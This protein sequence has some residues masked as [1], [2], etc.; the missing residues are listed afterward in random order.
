MKLLCRQGI[1]AMITNYPD[2]GRKV[3]DAYE[4]NSGKGK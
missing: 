2:I 1:D 3:V 4:R